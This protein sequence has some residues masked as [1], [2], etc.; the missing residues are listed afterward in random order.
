MYFSTRVSGMQRV[1]HTLQTWSRYSTRQVLTRT[2]HGVIVQTLRQ[3]VTGH[4][5]WTMQDTHT[6]RVTQLDGAQQVLHE[7]HELQQSP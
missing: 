3:Q 1:T 5:S 6:L 7:S 4:C 2:V